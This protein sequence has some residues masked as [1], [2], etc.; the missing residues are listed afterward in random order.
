[1]TET[2]YLL[3]SNIFIEASRR[4]YHFDICPAFWRF[5]IDFSHFDKVFSI[6]RVRSELIPKSGKVNGEDE[7]Q[8]VLWIQD[9]APETMFK[10]CSDMLVTEAYSKIVQS[11]TGNSQ[12]YGHAKAEFADVADSWLIAYAL[13][14]EMTVVTHEGNSRDA[15][16][17]ILIPVVCEQFNIPCITLFEMLL[18]M[19]VKFWPYSIVSTGIFE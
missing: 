6:D 15:K 11:V 8:L 1:M 3:D 13:A 17:R 9:K 10:N 7:D 12:Y 16:K 2:R 18:Q 5:L 4:Y 19:R 14:H